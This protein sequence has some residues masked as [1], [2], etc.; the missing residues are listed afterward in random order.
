MKLP[1]I[2]LVLPSKK[3]KWSCV[4]TEK[5]DKTY[6]FLH[7]YPIIGKGR[8]V[9][10]SKQKVGRRVKQIH[11]YTFY[12]VMNQVEQIF[13][14]GFLWP[15][16]NKK[17]GWMEPIVLELPSDCFTSKN[18]KNLAKKIRNPN[19]EYQVVP[20]SSLNSKHKSNHSSQ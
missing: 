13:E 8:V 5:W 1:N 3:P 4:F 10:S 9:G 6:F 19:F 7:T 18:N 20:G 17:R 12:L 15:E 2:N 14:F 16:N 11:C